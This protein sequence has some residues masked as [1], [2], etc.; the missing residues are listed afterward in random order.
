MH[1]I[2]GPLAKNRR[3]QEEIENAQT[4]LKGLAKLFERT[5]RRKIAKQ[6]SDGAGVSL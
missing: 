2:E 1:V 4:V 6:F 3:V 5:R